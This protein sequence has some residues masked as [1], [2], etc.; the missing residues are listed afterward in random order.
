MT[1]MRDEVYSRLL[2]QPFSGGTRV[3]ATNQSICQ[4]KG[5]D[6]IPLTNIPLT[7]DFQ[8]HENEK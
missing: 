2:G 4:G 1:P 6:F 7:S 5:I 8:V 3:G